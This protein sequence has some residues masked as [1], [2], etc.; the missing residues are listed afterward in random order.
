MLSSDSAELNEMDSAQE[1]ME[2][3]ENL[4]SDLL[5][6]V[7][8]T[9]DKQNLVNVSN[10]QFQQLQCIVEGNNSLTQAPTGQCQI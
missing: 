5:K 1:T 6:A 8:M 7:A 2:S 9:L 4:K 3:S 10:E